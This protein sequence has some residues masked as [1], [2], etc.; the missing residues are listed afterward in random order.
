[1]KNILIAFIVGVAIF[2][3]FGTVM[4]IIGSTTGI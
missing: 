2:A 1:M 3:L 4:G